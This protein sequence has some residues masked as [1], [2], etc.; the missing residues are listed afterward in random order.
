MKKIIAL[1]LVIGCIFALTACKLF[2]RD[3][4]EESKVDADAVAA[5][6]AKI[7]AS[8]PDGAVIRVT[9]TGDLGDLNSKYDVIYNAD[10][11]ATVVYSYEVF[12]SFDE[13][14]TFDGPKTVKTGTVTVEADGALSDEVGGT[15]FV[16]SV[17]FNIKLDA[18]KLSSAAESAGV[19][20]AKI[21]ANN[22]AAILGVS[23][24]SDV[25]LLISTGSD[26]VTSVVISYTTSSGDI[27]ISTTYV[28]LEDTSETTEE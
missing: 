17:T 25:D 2:S 16:E 3:D 21:P 11:T 15:A 27:E 5:M 1:I 9:L 10:G 13:T 28:Y 22:T 23:V 6:Q 18:S 19:L 26:G 12:N 20:S 24:G 8:A 4:V 7:D 14:E